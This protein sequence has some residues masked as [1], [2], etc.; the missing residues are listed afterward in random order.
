MKGPFDTHAY[1]KQLT[2]AGVPEPQAEVHAQV[3]S[4]AV[5]ERLATKDDLQLLKQE[6]RS[7]FRSGLKDLELRVTLRFGAMQVAS[8]AIIVALIKLL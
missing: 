5:I 1:V 3:L 2:A 6:F 7:E 4:E 8:T